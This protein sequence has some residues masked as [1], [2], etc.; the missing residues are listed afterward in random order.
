[1][2]TWSLFWVRK[3]KFTVYS[4]VLLSNSSSSKFNVNLFVQ[5]VFRDSIGP[6]LDKSAFSLLKIGDKNPFDLLLQNI[7]KVLKY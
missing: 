3:P 1:M 6:Q 5:L 2:Q 7:E 4:L